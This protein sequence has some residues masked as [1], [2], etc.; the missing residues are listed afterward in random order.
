M[1]VNYNTKCAHRRNRTYS[2]S[3]VKEAP[4]TNAKSDKDASH[5]IKAPGSPSVDGSTTI[6]HT[7]YSKREI[8]LRY[9]HLGRHIFPEMS[10]YLP[11]ILESFLQPTWFGVGVSR[12]SRISVLPNVGAVAA[13]IVPRRWL[14]EDMK[15]SFIVCRDFGG[16]W[17]I[18]NTEWIKDVKAD[19]GGDYSPCGLTRFINKVNAWISRHTSFILFDEARGYV[20]EH[21]FINDQLFVYSYDEYT[22]ILEP[23]T[24]IS[25]LPAG[26]VNIHSIRNHTMVVS[27]GSVFH[28]YDL[29]EK[30]D[31]GWTRLSSAS[32]DSNTVKLPV[33]TQQMVHCGDGGFVYLSS[34]SIHRFAGRDAG[35]ISDR[36]S[37]QIH[38]VAICGGND[39]ILAFGYSLEPPS[40]P[41]MTLISSSTYTIISQTQIQLSLPLSIVSIH[42]D[43]VNL[44]TIILGRSGCINGGS[45]V[46]SIPPLYH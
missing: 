7:S 5:D 2:T 31:D 11:L 1:L 26:A 43:P 30:S 22:D 38:H 4:Y 12:A 24:S 36:D 23:V 18:V 33:S 21:D 8:A 27:T 45:I 37:S 10:E 13:V 3:S 46:Q 28:S 42:I 44:D 15:S 39:S 17:T 14:T 35:K 20:I 41:Y 16:K 40:M 9:N 6:S 34:G 19:S 32:L 29:S 25:N